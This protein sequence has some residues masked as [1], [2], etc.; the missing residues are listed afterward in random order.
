MIH[1]RNCFFHDT[2]FTVREV[3]LWSCN[4]H[5]FIVYIYFWLISPVIGNISVTCEKSKQIYTKYSV[6]S[7]VTQSGLKVSLTQLH[8]LCFT[9]C[10]LILL[11]DLSV[12]CPN[13]FSSHISSWNKERWYMQCNWVTKL[14]A[15][16]LNNEIDNCR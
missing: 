7:A 16:W 6:W 1:S 3:N 13:Q 2:R 5:S 4:V 10:S 9:F 15:V 14:I 8:N 12:N 11:F